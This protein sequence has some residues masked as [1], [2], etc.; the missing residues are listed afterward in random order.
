[1]GNLISSVFLLDRSRGTEDIQ[2]RLHLLRETLGQLD[3]ERYRKFVRWVGGI[4][5]KRTSNTD[6]KQLQKFFDHENPKEVD[7]MISQVDQF[8]EQE[9]KQWILEGLEKGIQKGKQEGK[10][11]GELE[12]VL[13]GKLMTARRLLK[14]GMSI[15]E[16]MEVTDLTEDQIRSL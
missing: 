15:E 6:P 2:H 16:I 1:M 5:M 9:R 3:A 12:G 8:F 7:Q 11:E 13:K 4:V 10:L 14:K